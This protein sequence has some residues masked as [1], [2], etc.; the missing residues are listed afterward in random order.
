M[1]EGHTGEARDQEDQAKT[2]S[3]VSY[4]G[5]VA[6][7]R[8]EKGL[9]QMLHIQSGQL[10]D[11]GITMRHLVPHLSPS[12][13][14]A[15]VPGI[16][17][18]CPSPSRLGLPVCK[19]QAPTTDS[20]VRRQI[21][22][23]TSPLSLFLRLILWLPGMCLNCGLSIKWW[24]EGVTAVEAHEKPKGTMLASCQEHTPSLTHAVSLDENT[25]TLCP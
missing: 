22:P 1:R 21:G 14:K 11:P 6:A 4:L 2:Q 8:Q 16:N 17:Q 12:P 18:L 19:I 3:L 24:R 25:N 9:G 5:H 7:S 23:P 10:P 15:S 20:E 13:R